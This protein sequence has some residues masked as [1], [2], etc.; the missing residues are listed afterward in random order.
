MRHLLIAEPFLYR[1]LKKSFTKHCLNKT[2]I[3]LCFQAATKFLQLLQTYD[4]K[5]TLKIKLCRNKCKISENHKYF[6]CK[7]KFSQ[8]IF[9]GAKSSYG[10]T[11]NVD[12][13]CCRSWYFFSILFLYQPCKKLFPNHIICLKIISKQK[14]IIIDKQKQSIIT[15]TENYLGIVQSTYYIFKRSVACV[16]GG[17]RFGTDFLTCSY[18]FFFFSGQGLLRFGC[19]YGNTF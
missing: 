2:Y 19:K 5:H 7:L 8:I 18:P 1:Y 17:H 15:R 11:I 6:T 3:W 13:D 12:S 4:L 9:H 16:M 10:V 14:Q